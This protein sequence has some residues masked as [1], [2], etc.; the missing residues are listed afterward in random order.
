MA[1]NSNRLNLTRDQL[2]AF[3]K[4]PKSIKQF[5]RLFASAD[6]TQPETIFEVAV[7]AGNGIATANQAISRVAAVEQQVAALAAAPAVKPPESR[8]YGS[9][10]ST[11]TQ[12]I[13][14]INTATA[15]TFN[16]TD[17]SFGVYVGAPTGRIYVDRSALYNLQFSA[18][19]DNASG[20]IHLA[21]IWLRI[22][23]IDVPFSAGQLRLKGNDG[24]L[25][26]AWNYLAQLNEGDYFELMWA[27]A[28]TS[29]QILATSATAFCPAIPSVILTVTDNIGN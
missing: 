1:V 2:A 5:E 20:G 9:F 22:N 27:A 16:N 28:D 23:G 13:A 6:A 19:L 11:V 4:D 15:M 18:Q 17:I 3:L 29:V 21:Y 26:A 12:T 24:E 10:Y 25:V 8:R 7:S 14:T